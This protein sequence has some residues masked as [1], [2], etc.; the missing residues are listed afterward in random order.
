MRHFENQT[1]RLVGMGP[2]QHQKLIA[3]RLVKA[4]EARTMRLADLAAATGLAVSCIGNY[5]TALRLMKPW[6]AK[7]GDSRGAR[8]LSSL[9]A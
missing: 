4:M 2:A 8:S 3:T 9:T 1:L 7:V 6:D 5:R